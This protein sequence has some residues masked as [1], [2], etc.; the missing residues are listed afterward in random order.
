LDLHNY[1]EESKA[2]SIDGKTA[3]LLMRSQCD[4]FSNED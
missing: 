4:K 2:D 3:D 1:F